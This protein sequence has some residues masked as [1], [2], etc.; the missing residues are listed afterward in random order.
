LTAL[1]TSGYSVV[2]G[3]LYVLDAGGC[4]LYLEIFGS[5]A[6]NNPAAPYFVMQPPVVAG[7]FI[8]PYYATA[9]ATTTSTG[10][11]I[12]EFYRLGDNEAMVVMMNLPP[13]AAYLGY[14][15]YTFTRV[16]SVFPSISS[17]AIYS[18]DPSRIDT[19]GSHGN[20]VNNVVIDDQS[21]LSWSEGVVGMITTSNSNLD[22]AL[23]TAFASSTKLSTQL[24]FSEP[25]G[26][27]V[28]TGLSQPADELY[29][30][31]RYALPDPATQTESD[32]WVANP[33]NNIWVFRVTDNTGAAVARAPTP[34]YTE[35]TAYP[36]SS[37][38]DSE[39]E[40]ANILQGYQQNQLNVPSTV[41]AMTS[42]V[43]YLSGQLTGQ[44]GQICNAKGF[45]CAGDDQD[46]D[47]Y[48]LESI[49]AISGKQTAFVVGVDHTQFPT[50]LFLNG[51]AT[52]VSVG[53]YDA[54]TLTGVASASQ[55]NEA[56][57]GF[58][59]GTLTG[60]AA[61]ILSD[62]GLTGQA[63]TTLLSNL[64]YLYV[65]AVAR[66]CL[67]TAPWCIP[68]SSSQIPLTHGLVLSQRAYMYPGTTTGGNPDYILNP[69]VV[70]PGQ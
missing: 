14:Q 16:S 69:Q 26:G 3:S 65:V 21:G 35:K 66:E 49:G 28:I 37:L 41:V 22:S 20:A 55:V 11:P 9:F 36:E 67:M 13:R 38:A 29:T 70:R 2:Q 47:S 59:S 19:F 46:T 10:T 18:P 43:Y 32:A 42:T 8:D 12:N 17:S 60:S 40:L 5:C 23:R 25:I 61:Q 56:V 1:S 7:Q 54:T 51:N 33:G 63:S 4:Q 57:A 44:V 6:G 31:L 45:N 62:L 53:V 52:Y 15:G 24:L 58:N 39:L 50:S 64:P 34:L 68:V 27:D 30:L 48:R